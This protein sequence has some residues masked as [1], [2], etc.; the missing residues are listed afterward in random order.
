[1]EVHQ[2]A[3]AVASVAT[4]HHAAVRCLGTS[5]TRQVDMEPRGRQRQSTAPHLVVVY[6]AGPGGDGR[7]RELTKPGHRCWVVA[8]SRMPNQPGDRV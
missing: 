2:E 1:M 6:E 5:G 8:P 3:I 7:A 4:A